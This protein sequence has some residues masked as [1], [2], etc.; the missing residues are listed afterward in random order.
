MPADIRS[1]NGIG[2]EIAIAPGQLCTATMA[3]LKEIV[4]VH[5]DGDATDGSR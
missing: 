3:I 4:S 2:I 5:S 1:S